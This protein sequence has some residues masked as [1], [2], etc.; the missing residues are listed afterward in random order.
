MT[1][2]LQD[3]LAL[4]FVF[5]VAAI[6]LPIV[7]AK[8]AERERDRNEDPRIV[9]IRLWQRATERALPSYRS[10]KRELEGFSAEGG[11]LTAYFA[12][13]TLEKLSGIFAGERGRATEQY[14]VRDGAPY[15][16]FRTAE[17]YDKPLSGRVAH[18]SS[19]RLYFHGD[20]L[21]RWI[22]SAG[23]Q[24]PLSSRAA[25]V[26]RQNDLLTARALVE[27]AT[28]IPSKDACEAPANSEYMH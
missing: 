20:S 3:R 10:A 25:Q 19:E 21:I 13:D 12:A 22:D 9:Q 28:N 23:K 17:M 1:L 2:P 27:C 14:Y 24:L 26:E 16:I 5:F 4:A 7:L 8:R 15:F 18:S 6:A 11:E